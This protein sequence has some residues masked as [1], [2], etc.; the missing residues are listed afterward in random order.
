MRDRPGLGQILD[1]WFGVEKCEN[2]CRRL[3]R[4]LH[5]DVNSTQGFDRIVEEENASVEG[6]E[7][8]CTQVR[9]INIKKGQ[10]NTESREQLHH[11]SSG[12]HGLDHP[13]YV[14]ELQLVASS[15]G[16]FLMFFPGE[17]FDYPDTG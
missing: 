9:G 15:K 6:D 1:R 2:L 4:L 3:D 12:F 11:R 16:V 17:R 14:V 5:D 7:A 13:H 10:P 8:R